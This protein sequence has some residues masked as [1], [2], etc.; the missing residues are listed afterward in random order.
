MDK[1][2]DQSKDKYVANYIVYGKVND[3]SDTP[4]A[5][6]DSECTVAIKKKE[7][8][9]VFLKGRILIKIGEA[10]F[11]PSALGV[12]GGI[13][14]VSYITEAEAVGSYTLKILYSVA[15]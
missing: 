3:V 2:Y 7:L 13:C 8:M 1:I 15:D 5:Y 6:T 12:E 14:M 4:N 10:Y 9:D 11:V